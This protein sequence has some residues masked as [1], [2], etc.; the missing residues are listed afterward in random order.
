[1]LM[2]VIIDAR[3]MHILVEATRIERDAWE[4]KA[5]QVMRPD[6]RRA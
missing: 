6:I 4:G 3:N 5:V 1:M 2:K